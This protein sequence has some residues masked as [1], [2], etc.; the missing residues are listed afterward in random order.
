VS[1]VERGAVTVVAFVKTHGGPAVTSL[2]AMSM[3]LLFTPLVDASED[4]P[5]NISST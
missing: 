2:R 1:K 3:M 5:L 4:P